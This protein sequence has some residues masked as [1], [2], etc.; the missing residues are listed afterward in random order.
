MLIRLSKLEIWNDE[1]GGFGDRRG[2]DFFVKNQYLLIC[3]SQGNGNLLQGGILKQK[4]KGGSK[5]TLELTFKIEKK[6]ICE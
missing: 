5:G 1:P 6:R 2:E 4:N 3:Q